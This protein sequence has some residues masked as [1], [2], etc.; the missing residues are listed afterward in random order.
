MKKILLLLIAI[1]SIQFIYGDPV[2]QTPF[3]YTQPDGTKITLRNRGDEYSSWVETTGN[4]IVVK[5][6]A[7]YYVY[8]TIKNGEI[9]ASGIKVKNTPN[10]KRALAASGISGR[11]EI[12][13]VISDERKA[14]IAY[15][16]SAMEAERYAEDE[17]DET[18]TRSSAPVMRKAA[19]AKGPATPLAQI[20]DQRVLCILM[21]FKDQGKQFKK[22]KQDFENL[23]NK[24]GYNGATGQRSVRDFY[25][26]NSY[27]FVDVQATV[28]GPFT[29]KY[30]YSHY[31]GTTKEKRYDKAKELMKEA[32]NAA[33]K[34]GVDLKQFDRNGNDTVDCIHIVFAGIEYSDD[35]K[36]GLFN[37]HHNYAKVTKNGVKT[38]D[39]IITPELHSFYTSEIAPI[40]SVCHEYGHVLGAPDFYDTNGV[41][42]GTGDWDVM[43]GGSENNFGRCPAHHNPYTKAYIFKW[44]TPVTI[45][46]SVANT[47][48]TMTP[49]VT[50][51]CIYRING[52]DTDDFFLIENKL[53]NPKDP[54]QDHSFNAWTPA[55][56]YNGH[57]CGMLIYH[58][59]SQALMTAYTLLHRANDQY[60]QGCYIV[61][62]NSTYPYPNETPASYGLDDEVWPYPYNNKRFFTSNS[63]PSAT[64]TMTHTPTGVDICFIQNASNHYD[65]KFVVNPQI[66]GSNTLT[67]QATYEVP[68]VPNDASIKWTYTYNSGTSFPTG[69]QLLY[70]PI[71]FVEGDNTS[72]VLVERGK[73]PVQKIDGPIIRDDEIKNAARRVAAQLPSTTEWAYFSGTV[74]LKATI[75]YGGYSYVITK[76]IELKGTPNNTATSIARAPQKESEKE[77]TTDSLN[78]TNI[79]RLVY[80]NPVLFGSANIRVEKLEEGEFLPYQGRY[81]LSLISDRVGL[82]HQSAQAQPNCT[83]ECGDMPVGVYQLV[84]QIDG[85]IVTTGKLLKLY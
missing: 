33:I 21:Q 14:L 44:L 76:D 25:D 31:Q 20:Q 66:K 65:V 7:G 13:K 8:A 71:K 11:T 51:K 62:A 5:N 10:V 50:T 59:S 3:E 69:I 16:D 47:L 64:S 6:D 38:W 18:E 77:E 24:K 54:G 45:S 82:I 84:L 15:L 28:V 39:Y 80:E 19:K 61:N 9:T 85:K 27:G 49:S 48:Y 56:G 29:A 17:D 2:N 43:G 32:V 52:R 30:N 58:I 35:T 60:P 1:C 75:T 67:D 26:E 42:P 37:C 55:Y 12:M 63:I 22:T 46:P 23:W 79:Y 36:Q 34:S 78:I 40:G 81:T 74:T 57:E 53:V 68:N 72:S 83:F 73:F 41:Y 4:D 70:N